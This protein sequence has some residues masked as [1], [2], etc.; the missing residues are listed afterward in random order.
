MSFDAAITFSLVH[1]SN[2]LSLTEALSGMLMEVKA[3]QSSNAHQ[4][5]LVTESGITRDL[6]DLQLEKVWFGIDDKELGRTTLDKDVHFPS[7][8]LPNV[9]TECGKMMDSNLE[10]CQKQ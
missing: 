1:L 6:S 5:I 7:T 4:P 9:V 10:H 3:V 2:A 8:P